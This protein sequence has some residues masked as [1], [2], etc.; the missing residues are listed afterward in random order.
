MNDGDASARTPAVDPNDRSYL[1]TASS[2]PGSHYGA[3]IGSNA[4]LWALAIQREELDKRLSLLM[5]RNQRRVRSARYAAIGAVVLG[6]L[7]TGGVAFYTRQSN[8]PATPIANFTDDS[9]NAKA[10]IT[11]RS[12]VSITRSPF[13]TRDDSAALAVSRKAAPIVGQAPMTH[14]GLTLPEP[15][16]RT[17]RAPVKRSRSVAKPSR[18]RALTRA[19]IADRKRTRDFNLAQLRKLT[20][21]QRNQS[22][23]RS[24]WEDRWMG[25]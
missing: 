7:S 8:V 10:S 12:K 25:Y 15:E 18:S 19:Q 22:R 9:S 4:A 20:R 14:T 5:H 2:L 21:K 3:R 13:S 1:D 11:A 17:A 16:S 23:N 6:V 24:R